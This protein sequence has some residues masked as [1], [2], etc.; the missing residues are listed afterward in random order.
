MNQVTHFFSAVADW[1]VKQG[2]EVEDAASTAAKA[3]A[4]FLP[5]LTAAAVGAEALT[6]NAE[7]IPLTQ[8]AGTSATSLAELGSRHETLDETVTTLQQA[9]VSIATASGNEDVVGQINTE[10]AKAQTAVAIATSAIASLA[11]PAVSNS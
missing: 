1:L 10:V 7:L 2:H 11:P 9:A 6:G 3:I 4:P 5:A 8:A